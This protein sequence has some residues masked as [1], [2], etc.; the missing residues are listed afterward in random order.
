[1]AFY[2]LMLMYKSSSPFDL[3]TFNC[4]D[5]VNNQTE[6]Y[7]MHIFIAGLFCSVLGVHVNEELCR[8]ALQLC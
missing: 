1:M 4:V 8:I 5:N 3:I 2:L 7:T 6:P